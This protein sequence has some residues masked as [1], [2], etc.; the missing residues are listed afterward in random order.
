MVKSFQIFIALLMIEISIALWGPIAW[1]YEDLT[2]MSLEELL[3]VTVEV[4]SKKGEKMSDAPAVITVVTRKEIDAFGAISLVDILNRVPSLQ[5]MSSHLWVQAKP[6][7]RGDLIAH[8][9]NHTL[10]LINGRPFR[11]AL[12]ANSNFALYTAFPLDLIERIEIIRGPGSVLYGSNAIA[13]VINIITRVPEE[14]NE[15]RVTI[16]GGSFGA[17]LGSATAFASHKEWKLAVGFNYFKEDGWNFKAYTNSPGPSGGPVYGEMKYGEFNKGLGA[18]LEYKRFRAQL[19]YSDVK[20]DSLGVLTSWS[21]EGYVAGKR[22][23]VDLGY[24][25]PFTESWK[26]NLNVTRNSWENRLVSQITGND[27]NSADATVFEGSISGHF[28]EDTNL[29]LG[30]LSEI[31]ESKG[32]SGVIPDDY[33]E[34]HYSA[35]LQVDHRPLD[36]L[37]LIAGAQ[38]NQTH[39][40]RYRT[41]PRFGAIY[42]FND[43][44]A[45]KL[46]YAQA[47]RSATPLEEYIDVPNL[48]GNPDLAP[49]IVT[50]VDAQLFVNT[51]RAQYTFTVFQSHYTDLIKRIIVPPANQ[52]FVNGGEIDILGAE[53]EAKGQMSE[54]LFATGSITYQVEDEKDKTLFIPSYMAKAGISYQKGHWTVGLFHSYFGKPRENEP[55]GGL[56]LNKE[57]RA[58][59]LLSLN[60]TYRFHFFRPMAINVYGS[61]LLDDDMDYTEF[62]MGW[63]NTLPIGPGRAVYG[64]LSVEF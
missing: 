55:L 10:I 2:E 37:K 35:Y 24:T 3:D 32:T 44:I 11:D 31:R 56:T 13:G 45:V 59:N 18:L 48:I 64:R 25:H 5:H 61:N 53:F 58:I 36:P 21:S 38:Y 62:S 57:A 60:T 39:S 49:E 30:G 26:L 33:S 19:Y 15:A 4:A 34:H 12:E 41:V 6:V 50:T 17:T 16:G 51:A 20:Y 52:T 54:T 22:L 7:I 43:S 28:T 63:V 14:E 29:V 23:F 8:A 42:D 40:G 47:F 9:D 46:L 27:P 1:A